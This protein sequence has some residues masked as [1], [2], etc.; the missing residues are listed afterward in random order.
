[1]PEPGA[2]LRQWPRRMD[3]G[4]LR[5]F[6][7]DFANHLVALGHTRLTVGNYE[8]AACHL[9][10]WLRHSDLILADSVQVYWHSPASTCLCKVRA[11]SAAICLLLG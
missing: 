5:A 1:V 6:V 8:D 11:S 2:K 3:P 4:S 10:E 7:I 9:A